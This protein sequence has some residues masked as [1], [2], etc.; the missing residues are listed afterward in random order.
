MDGAGHR[1]EDHR[2]DPSRTIQL[3]NR[4]LERTH[5]RLACFENMHI[6]MYVC[7]YVCMLYRI[8][9]LVYLS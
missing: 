9:A 3:Q 1:P 4:H 7:M 6:C 5:G 8:H 2:R